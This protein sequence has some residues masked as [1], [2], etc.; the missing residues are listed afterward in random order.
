MI[1]PLMEPAEYEAISHLL[2]SDMV[3][4][5]WGSGAS[6]IRFSPL[7]KKYCSLE[8]KPGWFRRVRPQVAGTA[9][10]RVVPCA[11]GQYEP[12]VKAV[13][14]FG[15]KFDLVLIDGRSR[16]ACAREVIPF[17][18]PRHLVLLH[19]CQ[20]RRYRPILQWYR[21]VDR[22]DFTAFLELRT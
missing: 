4:M 6:T 21:Q 11:Q 15:E 9:D 18:K 7:V 12:Y 3:V 14:D 8:H 20:R 10:Y 5:E 13:A 2:T 19:D 16:V 17:L 1:R 22:L